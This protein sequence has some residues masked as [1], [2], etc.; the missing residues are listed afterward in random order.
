MSDNIS[1]VFGSGFLSSLMSINVIVEIDKDEG[2]SDN[3]CVDEMMRENSSLP[4]ATDA[5]AHLQNV[6]DAQKS[7]RG[8]KLTFPVD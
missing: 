7:R 2:E 3:E 4:T 6:S 5:T 1:S 8:E